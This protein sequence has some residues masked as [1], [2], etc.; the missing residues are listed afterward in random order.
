MSTDVYNKIKTC[1]R[2]VKRKT[3]PEHAAPLVNIKT[4]RP[5][6]LVCMDFLSLEPDRRVKDILVIT[7]H[8]TKYA[9]AV[10]T[11]NQKARTVAKCL[12]EKFFVHYGIPERLHSDQGPDFESRTIK[13][14]CDIA[15]I[16]KGRTTPYHPRGNPVERFNRTLLNMLGTL[17]EQNKSRWKDFVKP[18]VHAYNC[19]KNDVTGFSPYELMFGRQPRLPIDVA[20][21][22]PLEEDTS[23]SHLQYVQRLKTHLQDSHQLAAE[24]SEKVMSRNKTSFDRRITTSELAVGDRVLVR[25]VRL[26]GK[27]KLADKWE[28]DI[29][30]VVKRAGNLPVYTVKPENQDKPLRTLHRDLLLPCNYLAERSPVKNLPVKRKKHL[31]VNLPD[32]DNEDASEDEIISPLYDPSSFELVKFI[33]VVNSPVPPVQ[34]FV[35]PADLPEVPDQPP[36]SAAEEE[37][38]LEQELPVVTE[39]PREFQPVDREA[40]NISSETNDSAGDA[41]GDPA[42]EGGPEPVTPEPSTNNMEPEVDLIVQTEPSS[43]ETESSSPETEPSSL[44]GEPSLRRSTRARRPPERLQYSQLGHPLLKSIQLLFHGLTT[45]FTHALEGT[46][47][48]EHMTVPGII[49][50]AIQT[51]PGPCTGTCMGSGGEHVTHVTA[52]PQPPSL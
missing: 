15:G 21:G 10:P 22:L 3:L 51:Q 11:P 29:Y 35:P 40:V 45:A 49:Q 30:V 34:Q 23:T 7:D 37:E 9:V 5:L 24:N 13:E 41:A 2:C 48:D 17:S 39:E 42:A 43:P 44:E 6:E 28:P 4:S 20:F 36:S 16:H 26:R 12:W 14:L 1:E 52:T 47:D 25:N 18:L 32:P 46:E 50:P 33:T 31:P 38:D 19:T 27:H 8:F